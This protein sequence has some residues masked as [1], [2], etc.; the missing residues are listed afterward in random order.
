MMTPEKINKA[1]EWIATFRSVKE[2]D[3]PEVQEFVDTLDEA[4]ECLMERV[5]E[6][7]QRVEDIRQSIEFDVQYAQAFASI[8]RT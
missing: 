2:G 6:E 3:Q 5:L 8:I 1:R 4:L 7:A